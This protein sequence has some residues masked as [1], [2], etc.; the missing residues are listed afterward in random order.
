MASCANTVPLSSPWERMNTA[1]ADKF[2]V[3]PD[4]CRL[5]NTDL[6]SFDNLIWYL[7][8]KLTKLQYTANLKHSLH[9]YIINM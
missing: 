5:V 6:I 7:L 8:K 9:G 2:S 3:S 1:R 4:T